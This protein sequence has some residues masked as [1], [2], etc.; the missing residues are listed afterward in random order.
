M[1]TIVAL[2][3][4]RGRAGVA[5]IRVSG[6]RAWEVCR[7]LAGA[8]PMVRRAQLAVLRDSVGERIDEGLVLVFD[9]GASFTG[10]KVCEFQVHGSSAVVAAMLRACLAVDEVRAAEPGEF[11]RRAFLAGRMD[12]TEVEALAD[13]IDADTEGQRRQAMRVLDGTAGKLV[14]RW[15][16]DLLQS[17]AMLEAAMDFADEELPDDLIWIV[18]EPL[19]RVVGSIQ[20]QISG[21]G[22]SEAV[23]DGFD[24]AIV[25]RVNAGKSSLLNALAGRD[26][27][28]TSERAGTTRDVIEV[29][30]EIGGLPVTLI[31][32][33]GLRDANDEIERIG[34][35][36][37]VARA[38]DADL[39]IYLKASPDEDVDPLFSR[40]I[41]VLS[42]SDLWGLAGI[43]AKSGEGLSWLLAE[44][45]GRLTDRT[46]G[47]SVFMRARHFDKLERASGNLESAAARL[48]SGVCAWEIVSEDLRQALRNLDGIVGRVDVEEVLGRIFSSFCIG[49]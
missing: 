37:G 40:D 31:D 27:A 38:R 9:E 12:L 48:K 8:V 22:A 11:T 29:R 1:D 32:T 42:K 35:E 41:V 18:L 10:E 34:I 2:A 39:R 14:D 6:D 36:R 7:A 23:R 30:M 15:R 43:S 46:R 13:L 19:E 20:K 24:V 5:I 49:K 21:R 16:E 4:A 26:A 33:A 17:L 28:I 3:T 44:I 25:G 45:E 47:S